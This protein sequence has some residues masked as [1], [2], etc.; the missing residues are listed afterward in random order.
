MEENIIVSISLTPSQAGALVREYGSA[1]YLHTYCAMLADHLVSKHA[2]DDLHARIRA[3]LDVENAPG[4]ERQ[5][6]D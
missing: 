5:Q 4:E 1:E 6:E 2:E 3:L